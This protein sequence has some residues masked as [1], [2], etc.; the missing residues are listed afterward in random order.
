VVLITGAS[1]GIGAA[2]A[3]EYV[4]CGHYVALCARRED[5]LQEVADRCHKHNPAATV[6]CLRADVTKR[7]EMDQAV[8]QVVEKFGR[9]DTVIANAGFGVAGK[10]EKLTHEDYQRQFDTNVFG[11]MN[12]LWAALPEL[13][14]SKGRVGL[15]ASVLG[16]VA[17][18][19]SSA[20]CMSKSAVLALGE[21]LRLEV[22]P[23]GVSVTNVCPGFVESE[24]HQVNNLGEHDPGRTGRS[25]PQKLVMPADK[26]AKQIYRALQSRAYEA[27]I[28]WHGR[29]AVFLQK[30]FGSLVAWSLKGFATNKR[31]NREVKRPVAE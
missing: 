9:L 21:C 6:V 25:A 8:A 15:I 2:L 29:G 4:R 24:I 17:L 1:S 28:T 11:V 30:H 20:Y 23:H 12:T 31:L 18:P 22:A 16:Y 3:E 19:S 14:K 5:R 27:V 10:F 26:A 7:E 13:K